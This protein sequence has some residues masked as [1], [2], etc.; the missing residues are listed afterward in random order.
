MTPERSP[1]LRL[2]CLLLLGASLMVSM[3]SAQDARVVDE[4]R[5][6]DQW[7]GQ[8]LL[9]V[10][11]NLP[12]PRS[13]TP[14]RPAEPGLDVLANNGPV[15]ANARAGQPLRVG[16][17]E[18]TRG[19]YCHA[20]S[21]VLVRLPAPGRAFT[22]VAGLDRNEDTLRGKGSVVFAVTVAGKVLFASATLRVDSPPREVSV[23][24]GGADS[25]VLDIGDAGD[26]IGWDQ[27]DW[28]DAKVTLVDGSELWLG[29]LP[30][31]DLRGGP[32]TTLV[33]RTSDLP[34]AFRYGGTSSDE[35]LATWP[36]T[37]AREQLD[38]QRTQHTIIWSEPGPGLEVRCVVVEYADFPA[39][40]WTLYFR[41]VG[42]GNASVLEG[43]QGLD[44]EFRRAAAGEFTLHHNRGDSCTPDSYQPF[45]ETLGAGVTR[46]FAPDGGR[47]SSGAF[48]YF[49]L[50]T[51]GG[52][53][54]LAIGWPGQWAASFIRDEADGLRLVAGQ[55]LTRMALRPGETIRA[56]LTALL[57]WQGDEVAPAHN[58]WRRWMLAHNLPRPGGKP[59]APML[60]MCSGGF[61]P[62]LKVSE[63]SER[64]F[65]E[66][67]TRERIPLTHW[68]MDAGWYPCA[69]WPQV[70]TWEVDHERFPQGIKAVSELAHA[71]NMQLIV[72]F[73]PERVTD[74]SWLQ[75]THPEWLLGGNLLDLGN[76]AARTW[77]TDHVD[78]LLREQGIDLYRQD[79]N[80]DPLGNWRSGEAA[81][82][83]GLRE[84][85]HVQGYLAYW[86]ELQRRHPGLL[87]DSCASGGR[88]NDL[89][90][91]R[92]AVPL[93]RSD[94]QAFDGNPA[95][96][97]GNQGH[98]YGLSAWIPF[99]GQGVYQTA[100]D[101][102]YYIR[103]HLSPSFGIC[104]DVRKPGLDWD[105]YRTM[106]GQ[107]R[108]VAE[109]LL[110]DYYP[111]TPWS[112]DEARWI[113]WQYH[114]PETGEGLIQAFRRRQ[115]ETGRQ[116]LRLHG[117][118]PRALYE[119]TDLDLGRLGTPSGEELMAKGLAV[120]I[121]ARP[122]A[123]LITY[124]KAD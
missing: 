95:Y 69:E 26:G 36:R 8:H 66:T 71:G 10:A 117:L 17:R 105:F 28:A 114:R 15:Q 120:E 68:W 76:P 39:L 30:L 79:F 82:R 96:A 2:V 85:L 61:F 111:L 13:E 94:Y 78:R 62:G 43:I 1:I 37:V 102:A 7:L 101:Q 123:A 63:A 5:R 46:R 56:P 21:Q 31:R 55:E 107:F 6:R 20:V 72:W 18:Y 77:L 81:D 75:R 93:L 67:F 108:Q 106:V 54:F 116:L 23:D 48:P 41:H 3:V 88:R 65:I 113:A 49:N 109:L 25:F 11:P 119:V 42:P 44:T 70:G 51:S 104:W 83:Q 87:I 91:L 124:R 45:V 34:F 52:G 112:L 16:D 64:Q 115:S 19:L 4:M 24:L 40:E 38:P 80:M 89:E 33:P 29:D 97:A 74:G 73:E 118:D 32:P 9:A 98:T 84:N 27:A 47:P 57:F 90:T 22:A 92:R 103:S 100:S 59:L 86:D 58:Q 122:G 12:A 110:A 53:V 50:Q 14:P 60:I 99:F 121:S 35:L